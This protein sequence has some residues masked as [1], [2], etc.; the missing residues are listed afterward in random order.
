[1]QHMHF[2]YNGDFEDFCKQLNKIIFGTSEWQ[3]LFVMDLYDT[4][5]DKYVC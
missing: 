3:T 1:M 5:N 2:D 4:N